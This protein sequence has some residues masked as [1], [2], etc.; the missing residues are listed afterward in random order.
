MFALTPRPAAR[1][2]TPPRLRLRSFRHRPTAFNC[3]KVFN[4][5]GSVFDRVGS[6]LV[7]MDVSETKVVVRDYFDG[8]SGDLIGAG[9]ARVSGELA[10]KLA[11]PLAPGQYAQSG[12]LTA[13][14][15]IGH[16][17]TVGG[18]SYRNPRR[19]QPGGAFER[20]SGLP[21]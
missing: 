13:A 3:R 19:W 11:G 12:T 8:D 4:I 18:N 7:L 20:R 6:D 16:V 2:P 14:E 10:A 1:Q 17:E 9:G 21:G 5:T 15:P